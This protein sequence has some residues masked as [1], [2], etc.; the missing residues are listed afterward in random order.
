VF[1]QF[2]DQWGFGFGLAWEIDFWGRFRRAV[3]AAEDTVQASCADYDD[4]LVTML[5]DVAAN[6]VQLRTLEHRIELVRGN[7]ELQTRV[8]ALAQRRFEEGQTN[9]L[10]A[11]QARSNLAQTEADIP[12]LQY[13]LRQTCNRLCILLGMPPC[14]LEKQMSAA[15]IPV[16]P[17][18][19]VVGIPCDLLRRRPDVRRVER[20]AA[21]QAEQIG[22]AETDLYPAFSITGVMGYQAENLPELFTPKAFTGA[23]GPGFQWNILNYGRIRN[24]MRLQDAK[25]QALVVAYQDTVLRANEEAE[26]GIAA[27]LRAQ[28]RSALLETSVSNAQ[29]AVQ[30]VVRQY[31]AGGVDFNRVAVIEQSLVQQQDLWVRSYGDIARGLIQVYRALG[32]GWE[33]FAEGAEGVPEA[34]LPPVPPPSGGGPESGKQPQAAPAGPAAP[35]P[36]APTAPV[37]SAGHGP[38]SENAPMPPE[39]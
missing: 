18:G 26:N 10:D 29:K 15:P 21:A 4:V 5:G 3:R 23:V 16:V 9:E 8:L 13:E 36:P 17:A 11:D 24:N 28:E 2:F 22:I 32:G 31:D 37:S 20:Q 33:A 7:V 1:S 19:V 14:E 25:F 38:S 12:Q 6:Y 30:I 35:V 34:P 27:F 39:A